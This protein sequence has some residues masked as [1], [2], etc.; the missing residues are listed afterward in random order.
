MSRYISISLSLISLTTSILLFTYCYYRSEIIYD[1]TMMNFYFKYY[2]FSFVLFIFSILT[3]FLSNIIK[4]RI[5]ILFFTTLVI[6]YFF[7]GYLTIYESLKTK[8]SRYK[9]YN[10][11]NNKIYDKRT[12]FEVYDEL[13]SKYTNVSVSIYPKIFLRNKNLKYFPLSGIANKKTVHC[14][15]NGYYSVYDSDRYGFNNPD[16]EWNKD[17]IEILIL[18][19]SFSH[20]AC[21]NEPKSISGNLRKLINSE[22]SVINLAY[23]GNGPLI[24]LATLKEYHKLKKI[25]KVLWIYF[26]G[27]SLPHLHKELKN[28]IL[29]KYLEDANFTQDLIKNNYEIQNLLKNKFKKLLKQEKL[30]AKKITFE[31]KYFKFLKFYYLRARIFSSPSKIP[32][33]EKEFI[34]ILEIAK[35]IT[36]KSR[37]DLYFVYL[38]EYSRYAY[39]IDDKEFRHYN[40]ILKIVSNLNIPII[41][42]KKNLFDNINDPKI[43]FPFKMGGHYNELGYELT[44]KKIY[45]NIYSTKTT[46]LHK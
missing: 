39:N 14:N 40:Q 18:G 29:I 26:E 13:K 43:L 7:E 21:V 22:N 34:R 4:F 37:S 9:L 11:N 6:L 20:G 10:K 27:T 1:G 16:S 23:G 2:I 24:E 17:K 42:I 46:K 15:E 25:N 19:D 41:N 32:F 45:E 30:K 35:K 38:P 36:N 12:K 44:A 33:P 3:F 8:E 5:F 31:N 28:N